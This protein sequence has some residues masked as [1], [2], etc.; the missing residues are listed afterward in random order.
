MNN[1]FNHRLRGDRF[2]EDFVS[3]AAAAQTL[4]PEIVNGVDSVVSRWEDRRGAM[5]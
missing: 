3:G 1:G 4:N 5:R 2:G